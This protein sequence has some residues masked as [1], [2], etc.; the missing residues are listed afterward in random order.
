MKKIIF[1][2]KYSYR[3]PSAQLEHII[4]FFLK[5]FF[6]SKTKIF[7]ERILLEKK[8]PI[9]TS[10]YNFYGRF[11][12]YIINFVYI[13]FFSR[14]VNNYTYLD[15]KFKV[16][17]KEEGSDFE[18]WPKQAYHLFD[19]NNLS[20][21]EID[22]NQLYLNYNQA[23]N[24]LDNKKNFE[25]NK[26]WQSCR[27][28]FAEIFIRFDKLNIENLK[29]FRNNVQTK[30]EILADQNFLNSKIEKINQ[31][32]SL[33]LINLYHK[34]S[35]VID[36][37][38]LRSASESNCGN[39]FCLNYRGQRLSYRILRYAYYLSQIKNNLNF[40]TS[41]NHLILDLGGG[42]GGLARTL[43][44]HY[45]QSTIIII[46]LPE[47]CLLSNYF[48]KNCFP[49]SKIANISDF[50]MSKKISTQDLRSYDFVILP[51]PMFSL[52]END[53]IDLSINTTSLGEM[54]EEMQKYYTYNIERSSKFFYSVNR[55]SKRT[56]KYNSNGYYQLKF[57]KRWRSLIYNYTHTYHIEFL[58]E[59][60]NQ[61]K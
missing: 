16:A 18:P 12:N 10:F 53:I 58:G 57:E 5:L 20:K 11:L 2:L 23:C 45:P 19:K 26:W 33:S 6:N 3:R 8:P 60:I 22:Y 38:I 42:Y 13:L 14:F 9:S 51:P 27:T 15:N 31:I 30:A 46:E 35:E 36:L 48:L 41:S 44:Y 43:K 54:T 17:Q 56:E 39:N 21:L 55:K 52:I 32:K 24:L 37:N 47:L 28:E 61:E 25:A 29:N 59:K 49:N 7:S 50:D 34:L 40:T 1:F 4:V